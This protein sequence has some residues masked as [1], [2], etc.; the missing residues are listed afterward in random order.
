[1]DPPLIPPYWLRFSVK[2]FLVTAVLSK[3]YFLILLFTWGMLPASFYD[4]LLYISH[5][6]SLL[7]GAF[8]WF[9]DERGTRGIGIILGL[10]DLKSVVV[11]FLGQLLVVLAIDYVFRRVNGAPGA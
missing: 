3:L 9:Y 5:W 10:F 1:M 6:P 8:P 11:N 2:T 4:L 7:A